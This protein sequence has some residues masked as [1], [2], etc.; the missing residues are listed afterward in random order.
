MTPAEREQAR[1]WQESH[2]KSYPQPTRQEAAAKAVS[3]F[4]AQRAQLDRMLEIRPSTS[5]IPSLKTEFK[6]E[7]PKNPLADMDHDEREAYLAREKAAQVII[8]DRKLMVAPA[9]NKGGLQLIT[10]PEHF[11]TMGRKV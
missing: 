7:T 11:K 5:H 2:R 8:E 4:A 3:F 10:D 1:A 9:Y 6:H